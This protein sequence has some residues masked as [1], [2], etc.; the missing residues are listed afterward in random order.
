MLIVVGLFL[1]A[2][3]WLIGVGFVLMMPGM[4]A[5]QD[6]NWRKYWERYDER[7]RQW[8]AEQ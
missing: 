4:M 7:V 2:N 6:P 8:E 1:N 5:P 3:V